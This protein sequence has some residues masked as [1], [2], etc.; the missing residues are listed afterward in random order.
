[1][2]QISLR[3]FLLIYDFLSKIIFVIS[4]WDSGFQRKYKIITVF[5]ESQF[6]NASSLL[7]FLLNSAGVWKIVFWTF[8]W[9][10]GS[11]QTHIPIFSE[12]QFYNAS[13]L[14][15]L[16]LKYAGLP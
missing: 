15:G 14:L 1:M 8:V 6:D 5:G 2:L 11:H 7:G 3:L 4:V 10:S 9:D 12:S 16:L 13:S